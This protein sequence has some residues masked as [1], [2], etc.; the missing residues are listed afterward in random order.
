MV[1]TSPC[2]VRSSSVAMP[3]SQRASL[4]PCQASRLR[5]RA[6]PP[7]S[8]RRSRPTV[9][10]ATEQ[11][12][13]EG[14]SWAELGVE[15]IATARGHLAHRVLL[16]LPRQ[17]RA[18]DA[19]SPRRSAEPALR[20]G[21]PLV[22]GRG[23]RRGRDARGARQD[24]RALRASTAP[25]LR[26]IVEVSTYDEEVAALLARADRALR[27][28]HPRAHRGRAG[29]RQGAGRPPPAPTAFAL[30]WMCR[31]D[32]LPADGP[33]RRRS[34]A[35]RPSRPSCGSSMRTVYG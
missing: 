11:L 21:R 26:V 25:L 7:P 28:G 4:T 24:R 31:A 27:R 22:L 16:L 14:A 12:L 2:E 20:G 18:A 17:A 29:G 23:R 15:R 9:L 34:R 19:R 13:A 33:G 30:V 35:T 1:P 5:I 10:R 8:A 6:R 3:G 32:A